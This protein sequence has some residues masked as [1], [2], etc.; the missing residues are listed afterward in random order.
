[1]HGVPSST[2]NAPNDAEVGEQHSPRLSRAGRDTVARV[3]NSPIVSPTVDSFDAQ[4]T[5][6]TSTRAPHGHDPAADILGERQHAVPI[7]AI[8]KADQA[9]TPS[10]PQTAPMSSRGRDHAADIMAERQHAMP[11]EAIGNRG[12][13]PAAEML[14]ERQHAVPVEAVGNRAY[15]PAA[16]MLAERQH[17]VPVEAVGNRDCDPA[18]EMLA[19]RQHAVPVEAVGN[20]GYDPAAE[21][22]AER[23]YA[24]PIHA[25]GRQGAQ[26]DLQHQ[27][28]SG[29]RS[30]VHTAFDR[31]DAESIPPTP[32]SREGSQ[33]IGGV[34]RS[35]TNS[36]S[37]ISP[38]MSRVPSAATAQQKQEERNAQVPPIAEEPT[39][40]PTQSRSVSG[41]MAASRQISRKPSPGHS[42]DVSAESV[43]FPNVQHGYRRSLD[44]PSNDNS[45]ARTPGLEDASSRRVSAPMAAETFPS[46]ETPDVADQAAEVPTANL[47]PVE[48]PASEINQPTSMAPSE[49][50][51]ALPANVRGR[52]GTDYSTREADLVQPGISTPDQPSYS[53]TIAQDQ[54]VAQQTFLQTHPA[55]SGPI[56]PVSPGGFSARATSPY[57]LGIAR[58]TT[59]TGGSPAPR[60][61]VREIAQN[62]NAIDESSRR[63][64]AG[65]SKSS[66]SNFR[67]GSDENLSL[68]RRTTGGSSLAVDDVSPTSR[69][70]EA[71]EDGMS[72]QY[73]QSQNRSEIGSLTVPTPAAQGN[74]PAFDSQQSFRPHLPGEWV[75]F[76]P[77]PVGEEPPPTAP[78]EEQ[79]DTEDA[80]ASP[81]T[82]RASQ[83]S[84]PVKDEPV[85]LTPTTKKLPLRERDITAE[86]RHVTPFDA[87]NQVKSV[88][89]ALGAALMTTAGLTSQ[90]RDFG[91]SE[92]AQPVQHPEMQPKARTGALSG[93]LHPTLPRQ[94]SE[95]TDAPSSVASSRP[96]TPPAKDTPQPPSAAAGQERP[97]SNYFS[98]AV[99]PLNVRSGQSKG[100]STEQRPV[101]PL[102]MLSTDT[103]VSDMDSDRLRKEIVRSLNPLKKAEIKRES[104]LE[105]AERTQDALDGPSNE[106][107][108]EQGLKALPAAEIG[109]SKLMLDKRFSFENRLGQAPQLTFA[110]DVMS[111]EIRD[112]DIKPEAPFERPRSSNLHVVNT[113]ISEATNE[114]EE[115]Q[116][117]AVVEPARAEKGLTDA[118]PIGAT[119]AAAGLIP[120]GSVSSITASQENA[121]VLASSAPVSAVGNDENMQDLEPSPVVEQ[122]EDSS[123][124]GSRVPSYYQSDAARSSIAPQA[125]LGKEPAAPTSPPTTTQRQSGQRI[126]PFREILAITSPSDRLKAYDSTRD[127]FAHMDTGLNDWLSRMLAQHP[128]HANLS[129]QAP[130][131]PAKTG[132]TLTS[133]GGTFRHKHSPSII[134]FTKQFTHPTASDSGDAG[135]KT[136]GSGPSSYGSAT[137]VTESG[138]GADTRVPAKDR[139]SGADR[140]RMQQ[141]GKDLMKTAGLF[142]GK[143]QAGAKGL[144]AKGRSRF[145][146]GGGGGR[147]DSGDGKV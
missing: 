83:H 89:E 33:S 32:I 10:P 51:R 72:P 28:S 36:T 114:S 74:R 58:A 146:G 95:M 18:A 23:Q 123:D 128:E 117:P 38:I 59:P 145:G 138:G 56:S 136:S 54:R 81:L 143:A 42:R 119:A 139:E 66:W 41:T 131:G 144:L 30:V 82:P 93:Y 6:T 8:G 112:P 84:S 122:N 17:A 109:S 133:G 141:R 108:V 96:P 9:P 29:F 91:S 15:D 77:T 101:G 21:M 135:R 86:N 134:K 27:P 104:I 25:V 127:T 126:P 26:T 52:S 111:S 142:G 92:P 7:S 76:A 53:P 55:Q 4:K 105:D 46:V 115:A 130:A 80:P 64:S 47:E 107:R 22:L 49:G 121:R 120:L 124:E 78:A 97:I 1:M 125:L 3:L 103:G 85:D 60:S 63:N 73:G 16:E 79:R 31:K 118:L 87:L 98:G 45:P 57:G 113:N 37:S 75:S 39:S 137:G 11:V 116:H 5:S 35:D 68:K 13:D 132:P 61:R 65:S 100:I 40:S 44:P 106:R 50:F 34:T 48:T 129:M 94:N 2:R 102:P 24:T 99:S 67:G 62:Y 88:G 90:T 71:E 19:E 43:S 140:E 12:Y 20:R 14:A 70:E 69:D 147:R 110:S